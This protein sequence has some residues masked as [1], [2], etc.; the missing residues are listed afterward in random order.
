MMHIV[1]HWQL[2]ILGT[3]TFGFTGQASWVRLPHSKWLRRA[4]LGVAML[5]MA[6][7]DNGVSNSTHSWTHWSAMS[8]TQQQCCILWPVATVT[9][10]NHHVFSFQTAQHTRILPEGSRMARKANSSENLVHTTPSP[11]VLAAVV[12]SSRS[13][14]EVG[15][16]MGFSHSPFPLVDLFIT[17]QLTKGG[18]QGSIRRWTYFPQGIMSVSDGVWFQT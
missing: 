16:E 3:G 10:W 4:S 7:G 5:K 9:S 6:Q 8:G 12:A 14:G 1:S 2:S 18:V 17:S 13:T 11:G 15:L